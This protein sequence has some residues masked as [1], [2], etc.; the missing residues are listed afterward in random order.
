MLDPVPM[1]VRVIKGK[2]RYRSGNIELNPDDVVQ[3]SRDA[4]GVRGTSSL[5][6][7]ASQ[8]FGLSASSELARAL[9]GESGIPNA[10][11]KSKRRLDAKQAAAL[12]SQWVN[13]TAV[14]RGAPA[15]LPPDIDFEQLSFS[16]ADLML[17][18]VQS[19]DARVIASAFSVPPFMINMPL[20]G[21]LTYQ[22]PE[23]LFEVWWR[24]ELRP[25]ALRFTRALSANMLP[26]GSFVESDARAVLAPTFKDLVDA[27]VTMQKEGIVTTDEVRAAILHLPPI[28]DDQGEALAELTTPPTASA[29][30]TQQDSASVI[31]LRPTQSGVI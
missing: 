7:Y 25:M 17:L 27:W 11:L 2:R 9:A 14:R 12:Q 16:M 28:A 18:D 23:T 10:V 5:R 31:A 26:R 6:S 8:L 20:E 21:G 3:I 4:G 1:D 30:P 29:S 24:T 22:N 19:F 13:N 15:I